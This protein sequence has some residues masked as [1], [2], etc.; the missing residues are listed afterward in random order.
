MNQ[1]AESL[2]LK[3][4]RSPHYVYFYISIFL[5]TICLVS[6]SVTLLEDKPNKNLKKE[7]R[8]ILYVFSG[9]IF[10][11]GIISYYKQFL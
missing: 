7:C 6:L 4:N 3:H 11:L 10:F 8:I 5:I 2:L 1:S 9:I